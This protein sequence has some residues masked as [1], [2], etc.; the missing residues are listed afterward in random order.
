V[1][2]IVQIATYFVL[3]YHGTPKLITFSKNTL[4]SFSDRYYSN[5]SCTKRFRR[6]RLFLRKVM[7]K[8]RLGPSTFSTYVL[9]VICQQCQKIMWNKRAIRS[10]AYQ[11][12]RYR[13]ICCVENI[14]LRR[15]RSCLFVSTKKKTQ[16]SLQLSVQ[17]NFA[18]YGPKNIPWATKARIFIINKL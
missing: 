13:R 7:E 15:K 10:N 14:R 17:K 4:L 2:N 5:L 16:Q 3:R 18:R 11:F 9:T 8:K 12:S 6:K 1:N